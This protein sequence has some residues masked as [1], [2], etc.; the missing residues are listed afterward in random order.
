MPRTL[1]HFVIP[2]G[3]T[4]HEIVCQITEPDAEPGVIS[5]GDENWNH[6]FET[7]E[8]DGSVIVELLDE[9]FIVSPSTGRSARGANIMDANDGLYLG[10][11]EHSPTFPLVALG[12]K[13]LYT[14]S[15]NFKG[16][17]RTE[18]P[19]LIRRLCKIT[20]ARSSDVSP[21]G[22]K[23]VV[24]QA[25]VS[26]DTARG[27]IGS[28][29]QMKTFRSK[30]GLLLLVAEYLNDAN[31][32]KGESG[33]AVTLESVA[34][35]QHELEALKRQLPFLMDLKAGSSAD[36]KASSMYEDVYDQLCEKF[37]PHIF[38]DQHGSYIGPHTLCNSVVENVEALIQFWIK[39][40]DDAKF[41][42]GE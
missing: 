14:V 39:N 15:K 29:M 7:R 23:S 13:W 2:A 20:A 31:F 24:A 38:P 22:G 12:D 41:P 27:R 30:M 6:M 35:L 10:L 4:H 8:G 37:D 3:R 40:R 5:W 11:N 1:T 25:D 33:E 21:G 28:F 19:M 17:A 18:D 34:D 26:Y 16:D 42:L 36:S 9:F 32:I